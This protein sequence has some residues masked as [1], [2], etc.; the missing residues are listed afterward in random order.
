MID[1]LL[2]IL[3]G[4]ALAA[5]YF[6][7]KGETP[8]KASAELSNLENRIK[9]MSQ[10]GDELAQKIASAAAQIGATIEA[11]VTAG[12]AAGVEA[13]K[14]DHA[15]DLTNIGNAVDTLQAAIPPAEG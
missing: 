11:K 15:N 6:H 10:A 2:G 3:L 9:A 4:A 14:T 1:F 5:G 13:E 12:V 8:A 7:F